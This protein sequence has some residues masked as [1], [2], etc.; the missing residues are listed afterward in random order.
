MRIMRLWYPPGTRVRITR[1]ELTFCIIG[2]VSSKFPSA[3]K[4]TDTYPACTA[5]ES[6]PKK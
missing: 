2:S 4:E 1:F 6:L 3:S 5:S